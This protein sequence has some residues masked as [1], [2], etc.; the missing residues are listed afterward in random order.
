MLMEG[1]NDGH[2]EN[3]IPP[4]TSFLRGAGKKHGWVGHLRQKAIFFCNPPPI[5]F[6]LHRDQPP[7]DLEVQCTG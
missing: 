4:K 7:I 6:D 3:S 2:A 5:E 1:L